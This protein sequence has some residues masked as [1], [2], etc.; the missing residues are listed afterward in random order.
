MIF[1]FVILFSSDKNS[2]ERF[3]CS[4]VSVHGVCEDEPSLKK[5]IHHG[6]G[7]NTANCRRDDR[8]HSR[9]CAG[10]VW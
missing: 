6:R 1:Q 4:L 3:G 7:S 5:I 8:R 10:V 9:K 2:R